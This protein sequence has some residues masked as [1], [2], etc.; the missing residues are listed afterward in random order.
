MGDFGIAKV[1]NCTQARLDRF[2]GF[3]SVF[4][5]FWGG[6]VRVKGLGVQGFR[7]VCCFG[8]SLVL[9]PFQSLGV[10]GASGLRVCV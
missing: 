7:V 6:G 10:S 5:F 8:G 4:F 3:C 2:D 9:F 1:L